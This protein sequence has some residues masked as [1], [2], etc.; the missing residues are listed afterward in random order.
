M[1]SWV[2]HIFKLKC[3]EMV[4]SAWFYMLDNIEDE[5][6]SFP[7]SK[8]MSAGAIAAFKSARKHLDMTKV[9][10]TP[11]EEWPVHPDM[12]FRKKKIAADSSEAI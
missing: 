2:I 12:R 10:W 1:A 9:W 4:T 5:V 7:V 3:V 8:E 11:V 6:D